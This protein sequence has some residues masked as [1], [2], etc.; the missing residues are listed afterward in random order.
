[1][2][3]AEP[4][5]G[6]NHELSIMWLEDLAEGKPDAVQEFWSHYGDALQRVAERQIASWMRRANAAEP[7]SVS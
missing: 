4:D 6:G 3:E 1:M 5:L 7:S 2:N